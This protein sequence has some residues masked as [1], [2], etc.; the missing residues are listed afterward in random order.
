[1]TV[2]TTATDGE[3]DDA[4]TG[5]VIPY[6]QTS[7]TDDVEGTAIAARGAARAGISAVIT[8]VAEITGLD[9]EN[10]LVPIIRD[11]W[12][13]GMR[14]VRAL[15]EAG[16]LNAKMVRQV[17]AAQVGT[18][19]IEP[20]DI[21][22]E[23][24]RMLPQWFC[25]Q[26]LVVP[27]MVD[28]GSLVVASEHSLRQLVQTELEQAVGCPV[29]YRAASQESVAACLATL[30]SR[31]RDTGEGQ[32]PEEGQ[33]ESVNQSISNW[34]TLT[35]DSGGA[36]ATDTDVARHVESLMTHA[37]ATDTSDI[38][39]Q[40]EITE[41]GSPVVTARLRRL[42][43]LMSH[44][45]Y[46]AE[47]GN[48]LINRLKVAGGFD[49]DPTRPCDGRYDITIPG[50]G[51]YDLRLAG[52]PLSRG[53]MLVI[54][55]LPHLHKDKQTL[56]NLF[57]AAYSDL[58]ERVKA[59]AAEPEGMLLVVGSTGSGKSTTL[60]AMIRPLAEQEAKKVLTI[61][62]PVEHLISGAE[63][64]EVTPRMGFADALRGFLRSDP[65]AI[66]VGEIRDADTASM[67]VQAAQT[68]HIVMST[69]HA[70]AVELTPNRLNEM[71]VLRANLAD[72]LLGVLS[73]KL[74]KT[75]C[76]VCSSGRS[77]RSPEPRGCESCAFT[78]WGGRMAIAELMEVTGEVA[79]LI[80][81]AAPLRELRKAAKIVS[82]SQ[83]A[84]ELI[85]RGITT[86][87]AARAVLGSSYD[88][89]LETGFQ[90]DD[91]DG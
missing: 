15:I 12:L 82:Y 72:V 40:T 22:S 64:V 47:Q 39:I 37:I 42:G 51:R 36:D 88:D 91:S 76:E 35:K 87:E 65:D 10:Q 17:I 52:M 62:D 84:A 9:P 2:T 43:D 13:N 3:H 38:H 48:R 60:T 41:D 54:R 90:K 58:A 77:G 74:V 28:A 79:D 11:G 49:V 27:V 73:Q 19:S 50:S 33:A 70:S 5:L 61:E 14:P 69:M 6:E 71:G 44:A 83:F 45:T 67:A 59:M 75:L 55:M 46:T 24:A 21:T 86:S 80:S 85:D 26:H 4:V 16:V 20:A 63:Q 68:G 25:E 8:T 31:R 57:P 66:L 81:N 89:S 7:D 1:M 29:V 18:I 32:D 53:Q 56:D 30:P 34:Q 23:A 78:G